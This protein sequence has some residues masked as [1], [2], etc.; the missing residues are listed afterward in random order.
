MNELDTASFATRYRLEPR[1][2]RL[3]VISAAR[4]GAPVLVGLGL[5]VALCAATSVFGIAG[6][7][8]LVAVPAVVAWRMLRVYR[9]AEAVVRIYGDAEIGTTFQA[10]GLI[11]QTPTTRTEL[12]WAGLRRIERRRGAW[13]FTTRARSRFFIPERAIPVEARAL[14]ARWAAGAKVRLD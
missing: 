14:I 13:V 2:A 12:S 4:E 6:S 11:M 8:A 7:I 5:L 3:L 9:R 1:D 10:T